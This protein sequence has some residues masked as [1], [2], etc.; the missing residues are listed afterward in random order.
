VPESGAFRRP[1]SLEFLEILPILQ[2]FLLAV[3][4]AGMYLYQVPDNV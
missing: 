3:G 4:F 1:F 2:D